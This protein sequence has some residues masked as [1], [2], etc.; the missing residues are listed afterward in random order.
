MRGPLAARYVIREGWCSGIAA[1]P[2]DVDADATIVFAEP[3]AD[4]PSPAPGTRIGR[5][6]VR[7]TIG[8]GG[9][10]VVVLAHDDRLDRQVAIK[11]LRH[12]D[13]ATA[14]D[15][16]AR[17]RL[18]REAQALALLSHP[19]VITVHDVGTFGDR[20]FVAMEFVEG[21]TLRAWLDGARRTP[22]EI[23]ARFVAAGRGLAAAHAAGLV[24]RDFKPDNVLVGTGV[25]A[26]RVLVLDFGLARPADSHES[27]PDG[28]DRAATTSASHEIASLTMSGWVVGTPMYMAPEQ[29]LGQA[30]PASDQFAL[31]VALYE[32]LVDQRPFLGDSIDALAEEKLGGRVRAIPSTASVSRHLR[33]ALRRGLAVDPHR[34]FPSMT[35]LVDALARDPR[36][37]RRRLALVGGLVGGTAVLAAT[38]AAMRG[39]APCSGVASSLDGVWD[40]ARRDALERALAGSAAAWTDATTA[41]VVDH[42]DTYAADLVDAQRAQC[43]AIEGASD[44]AVDHRITCL[45]RRKQAMGAMLDVLAAADPGV[46]E[47]AVDAVRSL[48]SI[49]SC[50]DAESAPRIEPTGPLAE[51]LDAAHAHASRVAALLGAGRYRDAQ[52]E[53]EPL[54]AEV[55][56]IGH[57][58]LVAHAEFLAAEIAHRLGEQQP[59]VDA[60]LRAIETATAGDD[61]RLAARAWIGLVFATGHSM[62]DYDRAS[63]YARHAEAAVRRLGS[64]PDLDAELAGTLGTIAHDEG[65]LAAAQTLLERALALREGIGPAAVDGTTLVNLGRTLASRGEV[66]RARDTVLR[67]IEL[68]EARYGAA[69]PQVAK[70]L[71]HL[72]S[73]EFEAGDYA[74]AKA[75]YERALVIQVESLGARHPEVAF[76]LNNLGNALMTERRLDEALD[77]Y[78]QARDILREKLGDDHPNVARLTFNMAELA[79]QTGQFDR[80]QAEYRASIGAF[81]RSLGADHQ[82]CGRAYNNLASVQYDVG[83][84]HASLVN[85]TESLRIV[86]AALGPDHPGLAY[87][88]TGIGLVHLATAEPRLAVP[89][90]ERALALR[91]APDVDPVDRADAQ[92]ALARALWDTAATDR[93]RALRLAADAIDG[94]AKAEPGYP[95]ARGEATAWLAE[96]RG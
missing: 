43:E 86:E 87:P 8:R 9:M 40:A 80:A 4:A 83:Q 81:E 42:L 1:Y 39:E 85:Y 28:D 38:M 67:A 82:E 70:T 25:D 41:S 14:Q 71:T 74:A 50:D 26:G 22:E 37:A 24:H 68:V 73:I 46:G 92:F 94:Y 27:L 58:P 21:T 77:H 32:A 61:D 64:P 56:E 49:A 36:P 62:A 5:Y 18:V 55:V 2:A 31:C 54:R 29:H 34:R 11:L 33:Q 10:G 44:A 17:A 60:Y 76:S 90:L 48:P 13:F 30:L 57:P 35:A 84:Y 45:H 20:V 7:R 63:T 59:A 78:E 47:R 72:G 88:L 23:L 53:V 52:A 66:G 91:G 65:D 79:K 75:R 95:T 16:I 96:H 6:V 69:H 12:R 19:N 89:P 15:A 51:Q 3:G 93:D